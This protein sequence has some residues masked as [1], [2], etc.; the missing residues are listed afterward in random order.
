MSIFKSTEDALDGDLKTI[1]DEQNDKVVEMADE[2]LTTPEALRSVHQQNADDD[3]DSEF[4]R[5]LTQQMMDYTAPHDEKERENKGQEG[6]N[7]TTGEGPALKNEAVGAYMDIFTKPRTLGTIPLKPEMG[8]MAKYW[9]EVMAE[10]FTAYRRSD[11]AALPMHIQLCDT[12]VTHGVSFGYFEND[13]TVQYSVAGLDRF[14]LPSRSGI[15]PSRWP[16][17]TAVVWMDVVELYQKIEGTPAP[18][19]NEDMVMAAIKSKATRVSSQTWN[20]W[21]EVERAYK[22]NRVLVG[23]LCEPVELVYGWVRN[24]DK[25]WSM[26]ITT[27]TALDGLNGKEETFLYRG[28]KRYKTI[29]HLLQLFAFSVGNGGLLYTVRG[30]GYPI[31]QI[32]NAMDV[33]FCKLLDAAVVQSSLIV[34]TAST[35]DAEDCQLID[36]GGSIALPPGMTIPERPVSANLTNTMMPA[37]NMAKGILDRVSGGLSAGGD[38]NKLG[39][40]A[41]TREVESRLDV[42]SR[43]N[44]FAIALFYVPYDRQYREQVRRAFTVRQRDPEERKRIEEMKQQCRDAGVPDSA[45][46]M[47]DFPRVMATRLIGNGTIASRL[48]VMSQVLSQYAAWDDT[49]RRSFDYDFVAEALGHE[50]AERYAGQPDAVRQPIDADIARLE[51]FQLLEG[52]YLDPRDGQ[53]HMV[54]IPIHLEE[55]EAGLQ[56]IDQGQIDLMQW[57]KEH[58]QVFKHVA[59]TVEMTTVHESMQATLN[60]YNQRVQQIG[61]KVVNGMKMI[62]KAAQEEEAAAQEGAVDAAGNA[63]ET[64]E[65]AAAMQKMQMEAMAFQNDQQRKSAAANQKLQ[66]DAQ[67]H[68]LKLRVIQDEGAQKLAVLAKTS[69]IKLA[70]ME[71][72]AET[73]ASKATR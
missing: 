39:D 30:L 21:E 51:N 10:K 4:N 69:M 52:D 14:K 64:P 60:K 5:S 57:T 71:A 56:G 34:Q 43:L 50:R 45:F 44:T 17:I 13:W 28:H 53:L 23:T 26:Y 70:A 36:F 63:Q 32:C 16:M 15:I 68:M 33:L 67:T 12:Y 54:H 1:A 47:I 8:E 37:I 61:E 2:R 11:D 31:Y 25:S 24:S 55:L 22:S 7:I 9:G 6:F 29:D 19:W 40:R 65:Q 35:P 58:V 38:M 49:G 48:A 73:K 27:R 66:Q 46:D 59:A 20:S 72:A 62:N 18:G 42:I 3:S 41:T